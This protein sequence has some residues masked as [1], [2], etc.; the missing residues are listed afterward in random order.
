MNSQSV[1][2]ESL[3]GNQKQILKQAVPLILL[4]IG[5]TIHH[6][7]S[8]IFLLVVMILVME[9]ANN[10]ILK[11][12]TSNRK[13]SSPI[14]L[15]T[16][17]T[18]F[19][20]VLYL[21]VPMLKTHWCF[22]QLFEGETYHKTLSNVLFDVTVMDFALKFATTSLKCVFLTVYLPL[23]VD[24]NKQ[25]GILNLL[26]TVSLIL[27]FLQPVP[28][29]FKYSILS[30]GGT[31]FWK[32]F[33]ALLYL[34]IKIYLAKS[35]LDLLTHALQNISVKKHLFTP[36]SGDSDIVVSSTTCPIC[37]LS[38]FNPV[39]LSTCNHMFCKKCATLWFDHDRF[40]PVCS[41]VHIHTML[42][43][44]SSSGNP[45]SSPIPLCN[46][47]SKRRTGVCNNMIQIF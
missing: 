30:G 5:N 8:F 14:F 21:M 18:Y 24:R 41:T 46:V 16:L 15:L 19:L 6:E 25:G 45:P 44:K 4:F 36:V 28:E 38:M 17:S 33:C 27:R 40:C 9:H 2:E 3:W 42:L 23:N 7:A 12:T 35:R 10:I 37:H 1:H 22:N 11:Q 34:V 13:S 39:Q 20:F 43:R 26:E 47:Q 32:L 31:L 29:W